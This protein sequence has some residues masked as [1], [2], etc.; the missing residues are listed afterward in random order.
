LKQS[1]N[2]DYDSSNSLYVFVGYNII[3]VQVLFEVYAHD[4]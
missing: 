2:G 3:L 4:V 1:G